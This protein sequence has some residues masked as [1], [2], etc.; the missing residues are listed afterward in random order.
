MGSWR[1]GAEEKEAAG[2]L[3]NPSRGMKEPG[4]SV[5]RG[6]DAEKE[7][8]SPNAENLDKL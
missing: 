3:A 8:T 7:V 5:D 6:G 2:D 4:S 1:S